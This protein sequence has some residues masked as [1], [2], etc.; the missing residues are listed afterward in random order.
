MKTSTPQPARSADAASA[1]APRRRRPRR[2]RRRRRRRRARGHALLQRGVDAPTA[3]GRRRSGAD[4]A[5]GYRL[6]PHVLRY[7][8]TTQA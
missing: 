5:E 3:A 1:A 8:E 7:Y 6:T 4:T 2:R